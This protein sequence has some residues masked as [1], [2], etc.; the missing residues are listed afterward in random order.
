MAG[1]MCLA[2]AL[3][4]APAAAAPRARPA[5]AR[6]APRPAAPSRGGVRVAARAQDDDMVTYK[7]RAAA[8]DEEADEGRKALIAATRRIRDLGAA[9]DAL[10]AVEALAALGKSGVAPDVLA[11]TATLVRRCV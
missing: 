10:G 1:R 8:A 11:V 5:A 7:P 6:P 9:G 2:A 3:G 4:A